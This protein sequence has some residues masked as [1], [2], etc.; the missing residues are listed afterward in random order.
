[1]PNYTLDH[2]FFL[3]ILQRLPCKASIDLQS[4]DQCSDGDETVGLYVF[5][6]LIA[7]GFVQDDGVVGFIFDCFDERWL[8]GEIGPK[9][10]N[11]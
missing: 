7:G 4:I 9:S 10:G 1:M 8:A 11:V 2:P 3:Q 5:V 6:E